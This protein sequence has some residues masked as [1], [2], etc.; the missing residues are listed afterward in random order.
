LPHGYEGQGAEHSSA[1]IERF[2]QLC[3]RE[4]LQ[5]TYPSTP[6]QFFHLLRR[7]VR[8]PFRKPLIV[9]TPKSLLRNPRCVSTLQDLTVGRFQEIIV[10]AGEPEKIGTVVICS[11]KLFFELLERQEELGRADVSIVRIEQLY[12]LRVELLMDELHRFTK[13]ERFLWVQE[14]PANM[15]A[16]S[17]IQQRLAEPLNNRLAYVGRPEDP[18]PA[19]GSHHEHEYEQKHLIDQV[20]S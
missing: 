10:V 2:L 16:W 6:A 15:G 3:A 5:I 14:E 8:Q 18:A 7:Q 12:P 9:F 1:R 20:F 19:A 17:F 13:A 11:G 4:N